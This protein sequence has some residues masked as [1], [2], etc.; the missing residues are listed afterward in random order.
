M[1][2]R[3]RDFLKPE[4]KDGERP[5]GAGLRRPDRQLRQQGERRRRVDTEGNLVLPAACDWAT[6]PARSPADCDSTA[7]S[8]RFSPTAPGQASR[9][10][11]AG[12]FQDRAQSSRQP[13]VVRDRNVGI[14]TFPA[15]PTFRLEVAAR[16]QRRRRQSSAIRQRRLSPTAPAHFAA[17]CRLLA[18]S[19]HAT[20]TQFRAAAIARRRR[21]YQRADRAGHRLSPGG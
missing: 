2:E 5:S 3:T 16:Q 9:P 21:A 14:G 1:T 4:F 20:N 12:S 11:A 17:I 7:T 18:S 6:V 13:A 8:F 15:A 19:N 10:A